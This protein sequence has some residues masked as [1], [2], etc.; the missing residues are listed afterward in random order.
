MSKSFLALLPLLLAGG[1]SSAGN[2]QCRFGA[3]CASGVCTAQGSCVPVSSNDAASDAADAGFDTPDVRSDTAPP[4]DSPLGCTP[5]G[6][7]LITA[8]EL[9]FAA[10][11]KATRP[12]RSGRV[13]S[14]SRCRSRSSKSTAAATG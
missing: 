12:S 14:A 9:P 3:D 6:D 4:T 13:W 10:G 8:L 1:C 2:P 11:L 7:D 5:N